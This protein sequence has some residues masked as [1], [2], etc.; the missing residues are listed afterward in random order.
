MGS[1]SI[2]EQEKTF[3]VSAWTHDNKWRLFFLLSTA[4]IWHEA[5][6]EYKNEELVSWAPW[7]QILASARCP[8]HL[9]RT[10]DSQGRWWFR[11]LGYILS[12]YHKQ[13]LKY[14]RQKQDRNITVSH[15]KFSVSGLGLVRQLLGAGGPAV[16]HLDVLLCTLSFCDSKWL[17]SLSQAFPYPIDKK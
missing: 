11:S 5:N 12:N 3:Q 16:F 9:E 8:S 14:S 15:I 4:A 2:L 1:L 10:L 13:T 17:L 7:C 6:S